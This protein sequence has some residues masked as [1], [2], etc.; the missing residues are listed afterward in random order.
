MELPD[1]IEETVQRALAEDIGSGDVTADL[2]DPKQ[3]SEATV[4]CRDTA[5][6]AGRAW[7]NEVFRQIDDSIKIQWNFYD[8]D[9]IEAGATLCTLSGNARAL[10]SGERVAL[11][12]LQTLSATATQTD[13]YAERVSNFHARILD[14]RKTL[15]NLRL[16]QKYAVTC[17]GG[18]NHR[19]ALYDMILIKENHILAAGSI[20]QAIETARKLHPTLQ[21]EVETENLTE[22]AEASAA[23]ADIIMLDNFS[24]DDLCTA[25]EQNEG[26]SIK[27]EASGGIDLKTVR[28]I[29]GTGVDYISVG[30]I[31]KNIKA[32]DLSMRFVTA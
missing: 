7:F 9:N 27:L 28:A 3:Q 11:N 12:F 22:F 16:E 8:A 10:L 30:E 31:T 23:N 5:I 25:V 32:I 17:G 4:T 21:V 19:I 14:T 26:K 1:N 24:L 18:V 13:Q 20:T 2:I 29:A 15:P 6:L